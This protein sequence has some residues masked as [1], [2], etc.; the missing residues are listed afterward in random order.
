MVVMLLSSYPLDLWTVMNCGRRDWADP[1]QSN[2]II[3]EVIVINRS[4]LAEALFLVF[5]DGRKETSAMDWNWLWCNR[6]P[7]S[8]T[9]VLQRMLLAL[10]A[11]R[12]LSPLRLAHFF[13]LILLSFIEPTLLD[14]TRSFTLVYSRDFDRKELQSLFFFRFGLPRRWKDKKKNWV[15][16]ILRPCFIF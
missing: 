8:W 5:A 12:N 15:R 10:L 13:T 7:R 14:I 6:R 9:A 4:L 1:V 2:F 11:D 3:S 16:S